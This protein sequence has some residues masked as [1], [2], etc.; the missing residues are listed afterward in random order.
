MINKTKRPRIYIAGPL[1]PKGGGGAIEYLRNCDR[2]ITLAR[3]LIKGGFAPFCPAVDMLYFI[4]G[5][6][7]ETPTPEEIKEYSL[8]WLPTCEAI[9]T[10]IGW[11]HSV[12]ALAELDE[13]VRLG[14][15]HFRDI[16]ALY[17]H[18]E[19]RADGE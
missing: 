18:F 11:I 14:I 2:M 15:P 4:G 12:G 3:E 16:A 9:I 13:A 1:N 6:D 10:T 19:D 17:R 5:M 8:A 7:D